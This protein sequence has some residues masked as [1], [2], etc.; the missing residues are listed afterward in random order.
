[1]LPAGRPALLNASGLLGVRLAITCSPA[2]W[3]EQPK[4]ATKTSN[5]DRRLSAVSMRQHKIN[6][7]S[8]LG[9]VLQP[10]ICALGKKTHA[11]LVGTFLPQTRS[12]SSPTRII[13]YSISL[14][15]EDWTFVLTHLYTFR[16]TGKQQKAQSPSTCGCC[17]F[18]VILMYFSF[19]R[20]SIKSSVF[21]HPTHVEIFS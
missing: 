15:C 10:H 6:L 17:G 13:Q 18:S 4:V 20:I 7:L 21:K 2:L 16:G 9:M 11:T 19:G 1:M 14:N 3:H 5:M 8:L 12:V